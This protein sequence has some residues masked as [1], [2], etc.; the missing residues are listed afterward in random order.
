MKLISL[1]LSATAC[2][3]TLLHGQQNYSLWPR[4]PAELEQA[5]RLVAQQQDAQ[6]LLLLQPF[7]HKRGLAGHESRRMVG[8]IRVRRYL[9]GANPHLRRHTVRRGENLDRIATAYGSSPELIMF[10]NMMTNPSDLKVGQ[11]L[12][13]APVDLRAELHLADQELSLWDGRTL[14]AAYDVILSA[15]LE[16]GKNEEARLTDRE[17][18]ISGSRVSRASA[19]FAS[20]DRSL[21][22]SNG[23][24]MINSAKH[25]PERTAY[26][27]LQ[28][29]DLN[30]I[31]MLLRGG[32]RL[33]V[34]RDEEEFDPFA[35]QSVSIEN[36]T[37]KE[38][39]AR[40]AVHH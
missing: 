3:S 11:H 10:I 38:D 7:I 17:G 4:R 6:A 22:F 8:Q 16:N 33:S 19:L 1:I 20:S 14:V 28:R 36:P 39:R 12:N 26:V 18:E 25:P 34:V 32:A 37:A 9:S 5:G 30:E 40:R 13:V 23:L 21:K 35:A 24:V 2:C 15:G 31:S 27:Q 29:R